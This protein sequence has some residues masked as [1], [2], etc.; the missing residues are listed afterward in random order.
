MPFDDEQRNISR[1]D[2][3]NILCC[4]SKSPIFVLPRTFFK[5]QLFAKNKVKSLS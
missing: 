2:A 3:K 4:V 5:P 1:I